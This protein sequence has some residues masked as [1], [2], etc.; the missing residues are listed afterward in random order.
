MARPQR[1]KKPGTEH[2][3]LDN[4]DDDQLWRIGRGK[5]PPRAGAKN[6][7]RIS[8]YENEYTPSAPSVIFSI[9]LLK[10]T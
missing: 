6:G 3:G 5:E 2:W 1:R 10:R 8:E 9:H 4:D 7:L